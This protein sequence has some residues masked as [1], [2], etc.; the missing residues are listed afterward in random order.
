MKK[1]DAG[2]EAANQRWIS[3]LLTI[4]TLLFAGASLN[5]LARFSMGPVADNQF[6]RWRDFNNLMIFPPL[7]V[8]VAFGFR[9]ILFRN[10]GTRNLFADMLF[11]VA[12]YFLGAGYGVHELANYL[13]VLF[14]NRNDIDPVLREIIRFNDDDFSHWI[15]FAA[16][17]TLNVV[18]LLWQAANQFRTKL[19]IVD[20]ILVIANAAVLSVAIYLNLSRGELG[21]DLAVLLVPAALALFLWTKDK[22]Q[23]VYI[24]Y[25]FGLWPGLIA[26]SILKM[27]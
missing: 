2:N 3:I 13:S 8:L 4:Q 9:E 7:T 14:K 10:G 19:S 17:I 21:F 5:R 1:N 24:Y 20:T 22:K 15:F 6:L 11:I 18:M 27:F 16:F 26:V 23:P 25:F 12:I